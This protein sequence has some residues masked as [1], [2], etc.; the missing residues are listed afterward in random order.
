MLFGIVSVSIAVA[1]SSVSLRIKEA[2]AP[3]KLKMRGWNVPD[4]R[5]GKAYGKRKVSEP[6]QISIDGS[7]EKRL[8]ELRQPL[9]G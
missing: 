4:F 2:R 8:P 3:E 9:S 5:E 1:Y 7:K 6:E